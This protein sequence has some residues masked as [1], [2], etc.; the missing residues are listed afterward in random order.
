MKAS[1]T[2]LILIA[3]SFSASAQQ[4]PADHPCN[5]FGTLHFVNGKATVV[6]KANYTSMFRHA[7]D[8]IFEKLKKKNKLRYQDYFRRCC[9][10]G[11]LAFVT[12]NCDYEFSAL[13]SNK[14]NPNPLKYW[15]TIYLTCEVFENEYQDK[16]T[17]YF[18][19]TKM[20]YNKTEQPKKESIRPITYLSKSFIK[21]LD[22]NYSYFSHDGDSLMQARF[23][24]AIKDKHIAYI[25]TAANKIISFS[26]DK[27]IE[28]TTG[29]TDIYRNGN[30][31]LELKITQIFKT[32]SNR[33][34]RNGRLAI[35]L[36]NVKTEFSVYGF[37]YGFDE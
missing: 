11:A 10:G 24:L 6:V 21:D 18:V 25:Q 23:L 35:T 1:I 30:D 9:D 7:E 5:I 3:L 14:V 33:Y 22:T 16:N 26:L 13:M 4:K 17:P 37:D 31:Y 12:K 32:A 27:K 2:Y 19:I 15:Q 36:N 8:G 28:I 20:A 29:Y 34:Y